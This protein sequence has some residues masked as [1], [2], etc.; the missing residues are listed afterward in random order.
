MLSAVTFIE[1]TTLPQEQCAVT[2]SEFLANF[3]EEFR[4]GL[5]SLFIGI[6]GAV[7][8]FKKMSKQYSKDDLD[9]TKSKT[10]KGVLDMIY[11]RLQELEKINRGL[12]VE[13]ESL[14]E[15]NRQFRTQNEEMRAEVQKLK[16]FIELN[17]AP[18]YE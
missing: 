12:M 9:E 2:K 1:A 6:G 13:L 4:N 11:E 16:K 7:I 10:E 5:L 18:T 14:R 8:A 17:F 3:A 15:E